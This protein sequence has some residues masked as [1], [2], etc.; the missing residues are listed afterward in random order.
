MS[1]ETPIALRIVA[2]SHHFTDLEGAAALPSLD[3]AVHAVTRERYRRVDRFVQLAL[4]GAARCVA[5]RTLRPDCALYLASEL[6]PLGSNAA[7]HDAVH[8]HHRAPMPFAFVNTLGSVA[9]YHVA[10]E[11]RLAGEAT[12]VASEGR[13]FAAAL[14]LVARDARAGV[15]T[16]FLVGC[17]EECILPIERF[18][19]A[20]CAARPPR[21]AEGSH[22]VL[23]E[24]AQVGATDALP[25]PMTAAAFDDYVAA[26]AA[27]L[28]MAASAAGAHDITLS[29]MAGVALGQAARI[30][31]APAGS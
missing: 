2:A 31:V 24:V 20:L 7:V 3:E 29:V 8:R 4:L 19:D 1:D 21:A 14:E 12:V 10:R 17:V 16:Q 15:A 27:R 9:A 11:L 6:G 5:G 18:R 28:A 23:L 30:A 13:S 25:V 26:E 22:W